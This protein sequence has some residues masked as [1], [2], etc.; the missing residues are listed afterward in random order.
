MS[1]VLEL[2][3]GHIDMSR[4]LFYKLY[5]YIYILLTTDKSNIAVY[6]YISHYI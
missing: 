1:E 5:I 3:R 2:E 4:F 6:M